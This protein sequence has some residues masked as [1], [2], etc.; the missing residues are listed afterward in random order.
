[1]VIVIIRDF[2]IDVSKVLYIKSL[3][4]QRLMPPLSSLG[5][6]FWTAYIVFA[7]YLVVNCTKR[8]R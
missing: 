2:I 1:M 5:V 3:V 7:S 8:E 6:V 4:S